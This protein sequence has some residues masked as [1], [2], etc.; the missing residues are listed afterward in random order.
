MS[1]IAKKSKFP[2]HA[3]H[4]RHD[5][6]SDWL[7]SA[8]ATKYTG[9][10]KS[11]LLV[12]SEKGCPLLGG[13]KIRFCKVRVHG[14]RSVNCYFKADLDA[15][16]EAKSMLPT[17]D[18]FRDP[19]WATIQQAARLTGLH[20]RYL[21]MLID[22]DAGHD[23]PPTAGIKRS[24][25]LVLRP[26]GSLAEITV[27]WKKDLEELA[28][29]RKANC[30]PETRISYREAA[31][32][33]G[34][35]HR[36]IYAWLST[37]CPHLDGRKL[38]VQPGNVVVRVRRG[39]P[40]K[41]H[42]QLQSTPFLLESEVNEI[43]SRILTGPTE[44]FVNT[45][46]TW[47]P[48]DLALK[49]YPNASRGLLYLHKNKAC[50]QLGGDVLRA[51]QV[52]RVVPGT[53]RKSKV[54]AFHDDD[55]RR[56]QPPQ[57]GGRRRLH[58]SPPSGNNGLS[59]KEARGASVATKP[60]SESV[61]LPNGNTLNG[62]QSVRESPAAPMKHAGRGT[63][64]SGAV[65]KGGRPISTAREAVREYCHARYIRGDKL[66]AIRLGAV[67]K[68]GERFAP[69][70]DGHVTRDVQRY[71]KKHRLSNPLKMRENAINMGV[72]KPSQT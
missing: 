10:V 58:G 33:L 63:S 5:E 11:T 65:P 66:P 24:R 59:E 6:Q 44:P 17:R 7:S 25:K 71:A 40:A 72:P 32:R 2:W 16:I 29:K 55:L 14:N 30:L 57:A 13:R 35:E 70:Q 64:S 22:G 12:W 60:G 8:A 54:W 31:E 50:P 37:G 53:F 62:D 38:D 26:D 3:F 42:W 47:W 52:R 20:E 51:F 49:K 36:T 4:K 21:R 43:R 15:I 39:R 19:D 1:V 61:R 41:S 27:Y 67:S 34:L 56:L 69:K 45:Q 9:V 68:F 48:I 18:R 28:N 46:G 23:I